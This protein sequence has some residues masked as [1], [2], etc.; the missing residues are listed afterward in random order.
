MDEDIRRNVALTIGNASLVATTAL[1]LAGR[2]SAQDEGHYLQQVGALHDAL[3]RLSM[4]IPDADAR[5]EIHTLNTLL[6]AVL[7]RD[8]ATLNSYG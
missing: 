7:K 5:A 1:Y 3:D 4:T 6:A 2:L 8:T